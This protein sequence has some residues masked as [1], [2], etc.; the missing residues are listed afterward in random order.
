M[1]EA[2]RLRPSS[3]EDCQ[4]A[5]G[6]AA[7]ISSFQWSA[8]KSRRT[9]AARQDAVVFRARAAARIAQGGGDCVGLRLHRHGREGIQ[10]VT[11]PISVGLTVDV[12]ALERL[13]LLRRAQL[14]PA[15]N[16]SCTCDGIASTK[17]GRQSGWKVLARSPAPF[18][19]RG[20]FCRET[21][22]KLR[23]TS[24]NHEKHP[25]VRL[26]RCRVAD[27]GLSRLT[28]TNTR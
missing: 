28:V 9:R 17:L 2:L 18:H 22:E 16:S 14:V 8:K 12:V 7:V 10:S 5:P 25:V 13:S 1:G 26:N 4:A 21:F 11:E 24:N 15:N 6:T 3:A 27:R 20:S 23:L 19:S